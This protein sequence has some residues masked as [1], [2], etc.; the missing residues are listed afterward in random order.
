MKS[1]FSQLV[2]LCLQRSLH[3]SHA[4]PEAV[5]P[6][7]TTLTCFLASEEDL[8]PLTQL[9]RRDHAA[10]L[11]DLQQ[12]MG[13]AR[14]PSA[15]G[16][17]PM[18]DE[19]KM[20]TFPELL[21]WVQANQGHRAEVSVALCRCLGRISLVDRSH[22]T[23]GN[24]LSESMLQLLCDAYSS[25]HP[26]VSSTSALSLWHIV[27]HSEKAKT[28]VRDIM[29]ASPGSLSVRDKENEY[30]YENEGDVE[31]A[32]KAKYVIDSLRALV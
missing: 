11:R 15:K 9:C 18:A 31:G 5:V 2:T 6:L 14:D 29:A 32:V 8:A 25:A 12:G 7:L 28:I 19:F 22:R 20:V 27:H 10:T 1:T 17:D 23:V 21:S 3:A 16:A 13:L 4:D 30:M 26:L 24:L